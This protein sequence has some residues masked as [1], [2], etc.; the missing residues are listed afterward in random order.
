MRKSQAF[1]EVYEELEAAL[2]EE[3]STEV[4]LAAAEKLIRAARQKLPD[5]TKKERRRYPN[6]F[7]KDTY[8]TLTGN[9]WKTY[10][11]ELKNRE[12]IDHLKAQMNYKVFKKFKRNLG[13]RNG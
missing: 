7:S 2:G 6:Y 3:Y 12:N 13:T 8:V 10:E 4:L 9:P 1:L 5:K 11:Q